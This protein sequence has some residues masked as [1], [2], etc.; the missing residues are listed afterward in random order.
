MSRKII[1]IIAA[2]ALALSLAGCAKSQTK[3]DATFL[4]LFDTASTII[5]YADDEQTF[6]DNVNAVYEQLSDYNKLFDIYNDYDGIN[7]IKTINDNAGVSPVKVDERIIEMLLFSKEVYTLTNGRVNIAMGSVLSV[8]HDYRESGINDPANAEVPPMEK[9]NEA[10]KHTDINNV[11]IDSTVGTVYLSDPLMSLDVGAIAKGYAAGKAQQ[12]AIALGL[13]HYLMSIGGNV[14][15]V[16]AKT[17][18]GDAWVVG[19]QS[20]YDGSGYYN[21]IYDTDYCVVTSGNYQRYYEVNGVKYHHIIDSDTLMPAN[22]FDS[23]TVLCRDSGLADGLSTALYLMPIEQGK[24]LVK[25]LDGVEA[26]WIISE[27]EAVY[28]D[29]FKALIKS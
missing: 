6:K 26:M 12:A 15:P 4:D 17:D 24:E 16:G 8:W 29:G 11:V 20:P 22:Y 10:A 23:V 1:A 7:N 25:S 5:G 13:N 3:Y 28:T 14:C 27:S 18:S 2:S 19:I 9:L 21:T